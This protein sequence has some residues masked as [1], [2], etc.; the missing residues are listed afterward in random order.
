MT[1]RPVLVRIVHFGDSIT[2]GQYVDPALRWTSLTT[3]RL[4]L[5]YLE[6]PILVMSSNK[7]VSGETTRQGLERFANDVQVNTPDVVTI[8]FGLNDCNCWLSDRG[9]PRV[10]AAA[11]RANLLEMVDRARRFGAQHVILAT[12][13]PTLRR[14]VMLSGERYEDANA[15]YSEIIREV[16]R[17]AG[18]VL[19]D[20]RSDFDRLGP[21]ELG[22]T[23]LPYPDLLHLSPE[24]NR[25]YAEVMWP[26]LLQAVEATVTAA[27]AE[28]PRAP[29]RAS[30][31][32]R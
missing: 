20:A 8:Q 29:A 15:R 14:K 21:E 31:G 11:F 25:R 17:E 26:H 12:N 28:V 13:H 23:L 10:S 2:F 3:D 19:C 5:R 9:A 32:E 6:T 4:T 27:D 24:G 30:S 16:A 7:G 1:Q 22:A 18:T